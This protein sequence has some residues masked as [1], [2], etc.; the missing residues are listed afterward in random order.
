MKWPEPFPVLESKR[1]RGWLEARGEAQRLFPGLLVAVRDRVE[2]E[3][4]DLGVRGVV[5]ELDRE[6]VMATF[7]ELGWAVP[8]DW[9]AFGFKGRAFYDAHV[10]V[11]LETGGWPVRYHVGLH[12]REPVW[13]ELAG[14]LARLD[15]ERVIGR[16]PEYV[17]AEAVGEHRLFDPAHVADLGAPERLVDELAARA[18]A[19]YRAAHVT[20][21]MTSD[22]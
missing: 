8:L 4:G 14:E 15:W 18:V 2:A 6:N 9:V 12:L 1:L 17:V 10:G 5:G 7:P 3:L 16:R 22:G 19:Y 21:T 20:V 11:V 13:R